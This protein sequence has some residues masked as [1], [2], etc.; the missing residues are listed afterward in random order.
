VTLADDTDWAPFIDPE[1][2]HVLV[3]L[4]ELR[5]KISPWWN[6]T[7]VDGRVDADADV[8]GPEGD[9]IVDAVAHEPQGVILRLQRANDALLVCRRDAGKERRLLHHVGK[10]LVI[11]GL[12]VGAEQHVLR[13]QADFLADFAGHELV[14]AGEPASRVSYRRRRSPAEQS[15]WRRWRVP[16]NRPRRAVR[17][18]L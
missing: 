2:A 7:D 9:G 3:Y 5:F 17:T 12:D 13:G 15:P 8:G 1:P 10:V 18:P 4:D 14:V 16:E 6:V 11:Q